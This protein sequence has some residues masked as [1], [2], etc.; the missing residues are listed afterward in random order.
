[1]KATKTSPPMPEPPA[2]ALL[3]TEKEAAARLRTSARTLQRERKKGRIAFVRVGAI[4]VGYRIEDLE[5]FIQYARVPQK[6]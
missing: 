3:L 5:A 2:G 1:M 6:G 4:G